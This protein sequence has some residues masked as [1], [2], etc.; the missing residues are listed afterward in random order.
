MD[1]LLALILVGMV[2]LY[3]IQ[4]LFVYVKLITV[5]RYGK[6]CEFSGNYV[7]KKEVLM[8]LIPGLFYI[9]GPI[10]NF[11]RLE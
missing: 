10:S 11:N 2:F 1:M 7:S 3:L 6:G 5:V 8:D 4:V 9:K